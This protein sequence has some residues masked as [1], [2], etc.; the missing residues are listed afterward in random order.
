MPEIVLLYYLLGYHCPCHLKVSNNDKSIRLGQHSFLIIDAKRFIE[1]RKRWTNPTIVPI[2]LS[3]PESW[4]NWNYFPRTNA[5]AYLIAASVITKTVLL[6]Y[7]LRY[8]CPWHLKVS[9]SDTPIRLGQHHFLIIDAKLLSQDKHSSWCSI[10]DD[11]R[12]FT[13]LSPWILLSLTFKSE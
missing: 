7:H 6:Y 3:M 13:V 9:N 2:P 12:S 8:S 11:K 1:W 4:L 5:L 10:T